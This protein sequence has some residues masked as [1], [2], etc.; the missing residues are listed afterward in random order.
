MFNRF[1]GDPRLFHGPNGAYLVFNSGQPVMD[2]GLENQA[3]IQL[4]TSKGWAGNYF[5]PPTS[6]IGTN[7]L[8]ATR[9]PITLTNLENIRKEGIAALSAPVFGEVTG[10]VTNPAGSQ[11]KEVYT[12]KPPGADQEKLV[13][14]GQAAN[15]I[16]QTV[17]PA[18]KREAEWV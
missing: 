2:Q 16:G 15:W 9:K 17:N 10:E 7:H 13:L 12:V 14:T 1:Q 8:E 5:L 18:Y 3:E 11:I 6:Q 4:T